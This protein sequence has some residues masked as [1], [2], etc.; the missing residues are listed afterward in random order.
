MKLERLLTTSE[1][2]QI[3]G[4]S[5]KTVRKLKSRG[6]VP[7]NFGGRFRYRKQDVSSFIDRHIQSER[8]AV[9]PPTDDDELVRFPGLNDEAWEEVQRRRN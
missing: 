7:I 9:C 4:L 5:E 1:V 8:S 2:A 3:L 6:L